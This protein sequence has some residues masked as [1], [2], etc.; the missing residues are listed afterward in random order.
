MQYCYHTIVASYSV[1]LTSYMIQYFS[2]ADSATFHCI[3]GNF[4]YQECMNHLIHSWL[5]PF[6]WL[7]LVMVYHQ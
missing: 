3:F 5:P 7:I 6:G 4:I 1:S 2:A